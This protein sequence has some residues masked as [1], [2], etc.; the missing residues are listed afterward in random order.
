MIRHLKMRCP[1]LLAVL[2]L[3]GGCNDLP[4]DPKPGPEVSRPEQVLSFDVLYRENCSG[5]HGADGQNGPATDLADPEYQAL[6]DDSILRNVIAN[7]QKETMMPAFAKSSGGGLTDEQL[8][9]I[10]K[11]MR[12]RW[13]K[14]NVL[15]GMNAPPY[16]A[17]KPGNAGAGEQVYAGA[18]A[19]CHGA[20]NGP[21]GKAGSVLSG[22]FLGLISPQALR[23]AVIAGRPDLG[24]PDWRT[25]VRGHALTD[26][27]V[28]DVVAWVMAQRPQSP[29]QPY[30]AH[31][32]ESKLGGK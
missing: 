6:I 22:S 28:T 21:P 32:A 11:G 14:G 25:Q 31:S 17:D 30:P 15:Q 16:R 23:I 29:G 8:D 10:V 2:A 5:C 7:G 19:Q 24:M 12:S 18:C 4:G 1:L 20:A 26:Q 9:A 27:E 3:L 13:F